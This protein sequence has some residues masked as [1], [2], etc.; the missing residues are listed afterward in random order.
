MAGSGERT[1]ENSRE[2]KREVG[3]GGEGDVGAAGQRARGYQG[4]A[5]LC[6]SP[7]EEKSLNLME[8]FS[9]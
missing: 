6:A 9:L 3:T 4:P 8:L 5:G 1:L 2:G 7:A